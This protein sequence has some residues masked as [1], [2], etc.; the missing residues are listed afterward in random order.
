MKKLISIFLTLLLVF[1]LTACKSKTDPAPAD[2]TQRPGTEN[3]T[4]NTAAQ[5]P[6]QQGQNNTDPA[7][8]DPDNTDPAEN[9]ASEPDE[10]SQ[11]T[12]DPEDIPLDENDEVVVIVENGEAVGGF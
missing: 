5:D 3:V 10:S 12:D 2:N 11:Q 4:D 6:A 8:Q 9:T 7:Q 1:S